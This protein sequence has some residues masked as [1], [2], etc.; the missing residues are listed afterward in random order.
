MG[1]REVHVLQSVV[2]ALAPP[3]LSQQRGFATVSISSVLLPEF[4]APD[5]S[6]DTSTVSTLACFQPQSVRCS[7]NLVALEQRS[8]VEQQDTG[9]LEQ[10]L[11]AGIGLRGRQHRQAV[12][13]SRCHPWFIPGL[14]LFTLLPCYYSR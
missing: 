4:I 13:G 11:K 12:F 3:L 7:W 9:R 14:G 6:E 10:V 2:Q 5:L 8:R 1:H